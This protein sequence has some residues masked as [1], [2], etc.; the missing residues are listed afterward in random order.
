[1]SPTHVEWEGSCRVALFHLEEYEAA[2]EAFEAGQALD[3]K[4]SFF[5]TWI[6]KCVAEIDGRHSP[7]QPLSTL[8]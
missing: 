6:R 8:V 1:M 4:N 2:K 7:Q 3:P 5:K